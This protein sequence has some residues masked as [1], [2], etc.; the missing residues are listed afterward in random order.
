[1]SLNITEAKAVTVLGEALLDLLGAEPVTLAWA[2]HTQHGR[3]QPAAVLL[4]DAA[5][6][7]LGAGPRGTDVA[8][9]YAR[10]QRPQ[11]GPLQ[12]PGTGALERL[13]RIAALLGRPCPEP[14]TGTACPCGTGQAWPCKRTQAIQ[15]ATGG[16]HAPSGG[17]R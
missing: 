16:C 6:Q 8:N 5:H 14:D 7:R 10:L 2:Q 11:P 12:L 13:A 9:V 4:A 1:M 17:P 15:L 3:T